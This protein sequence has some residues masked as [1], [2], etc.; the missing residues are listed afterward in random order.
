MNWTGPEFNWNK[1][2]KC[3]TKTTWISSLLSHPLFVDPFLLCVNLKL[4][5]Y[6]LELVIYSQTGHSHPSYCIIS[7]QTSCF[8]VSCIQCKGYIKNYHYIH[9]YVLGFKK[10]GLW[11]GKF[12]FIH[13]AIF[14]FQISSGHF[15]N[16]YN[17]I[18]EYR[19]HGK[20]NFQ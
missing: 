20:S 4:R 13:E 12:F 19:I 1:I 18:A 10:K 3:K 9:C 17:C 2:Q 8:D 6:I 11:K 14:I 15:F 7:M 16:N 5:K